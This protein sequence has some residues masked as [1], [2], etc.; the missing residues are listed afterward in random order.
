MKARQNAELRMRCADKPQLRHYI[1]FKT[2]DIKP[3]LL[4]KPLS[5][6]QRKFLTRLCTSCLELRICTGRYQRMPEVDRI[7]QVTEQCETDAE[8]E[9]EFHFVLR[10]SG[11]TDIRQQW[12]KSLVLPVNFDQLPDAGKMAVL[13]NL[14]NVKLTAQFIVEAFNQRAK[15]LFL[16]SN[17]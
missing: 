9:T 10:C 8:V 16:K 7:C 14:E 6:I 13:I 5:F 1:Q 2:F 12:L 15:L 3:P 17:I 11:Y 4:I